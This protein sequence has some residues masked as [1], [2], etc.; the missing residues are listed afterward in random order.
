MSL[1]WGGGYHERE[2]C[3]RLKKNVL[4]A[5][6][7]AIITAGLASAPVAAEAAGQQAQ[8]AP[9][10]VRHLGTNCMTVHSSGNR[11]AGVICISVVITT[12]KKAADVTFTPT[13]GTASQISIASLKLSMN[14]VITEKAGPLHKRW[15]SP[16]AGS[17]AL[18]WWDEPVGHAQASVLNACMTW[19]D[20]TRA[21]TGSHWYSSKL[22]HA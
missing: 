2:K 4:I 18:N 11:H 9:P 8:S 17:F 10:A 6:A 16:G 20:G 1:K 3:M 21:C 15:T 7:C 5:S 22:V 19:T 14:G 12:G 13:S